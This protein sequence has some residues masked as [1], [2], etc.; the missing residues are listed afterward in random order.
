MNNFWKQIEEDT[1]NIVLWHI[2]PKSW[3]SW[4]SDFGF[5][6][7]WKKDRARTQKC[8][9]WRANIVIFSPTLYSYCSNQSKTY[10]NIVYFQQQ[11]QIRSCII[12][13]FDEYAVL[14][15]N[16]VSETYTLFLQFFLD[17]KTVSA[18]SFAF[19]MYVVAY[20]QCTAILFSILMSV[21]KENKLRTNTESTVLCHTVN[22]LPYCD[23]LCDTVSMPYCVHT[24]NVL[25]IKQKLY[26]K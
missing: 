13:N 1:K 2:H 14:R 17:C 7:F 11:Q 19:G 5:F 6:F 18:N 12:Q 8:T 3:S 23:I 9:A 10:L 22:V 16:F 21:V 15:R 25:S 26:K 4:S 24:V 20:C